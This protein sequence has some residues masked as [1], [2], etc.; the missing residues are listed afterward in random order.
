MKNE[1]R[2]MLGVCALVVGVYVY[3]VH[4]GVLVSGSL[5]AADNYYNLLVQGF[6]VGQLSLKKE[7]PLGL[8]QLADPYDPAENG[9]YR[10]APYGMHDMSYFKGKLYLYLG[11]TPALI[12]FWPYVALTGHYLSYGQAGVIFCVMG[13]LASA[14]L[15]FAF[16][17]TCF[18]ETSVWVVAA[19]GLALGLATS[20]PVLLARCDV[21]EVAISC[22]YAL[23][24]LALAAIWRAL[25][26]PE[27][28]K[29]LGWLAAAS[30]TYGLAVGARPSLLF[31][32]IVLLVP[33]ASAW[34]ERQK[35]WIQL[36][37][38]V[39]PIAL[40]G[41]G[42]MLYNDLRFDS[43]F[44]FG[45]RYQLAAV[46]QLTTRFFSPH[47]LWFNF[48]VYFLGPT[49]WTSR[50]PFVHEVPHPPVPLGHMGGGQTFGVL[51]NI[52]LVWLALAAPLGWRGRSAECCPI[53]CRFV[54]VLGILFAINALTLGLFVSVHGRYEVDFLPELLLL[55]VTGVLGMERALASTSE[56]GPVNQFR[57]QRPM[58]WCWS[59]LL[60][61][62]IA[63]N[64]LASVGRCAESD[65][66]LGVALMRLGKVDEA[67]Q[68]F[69]RTLRLNPDFVDARNNLG[70]AFFQKGKFQDAVGQYVEALR[71]NPGYAR[72]HINLGVV[73]GKLGKTEVAIRQYEEALRIDR[74]SSEAH[75]DLGI[76]LLQQN[77][78]QEA[79][80]QFEEALRIDPY[81]VVAHV[82]IANGLLLQGKL[83]DSIRHYETALSIDPK[84]AEVHDNL[85]IALAQ[86]GRVPE[87]IKH[88]GEAL[89]LKPDDAEAHL[90]L[91]L[92]LE[93]LGRTTE[94]IEHY[95]QALKIRPDF[96]PARDALTR[97]GAV[98]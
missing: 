78:L 61:L 64:L 94:A 54:T 66:N 5:S 95:Q 62:S 82:S 67:M 7:V 59:I 18:A 84:N 80:A 36:L 15:L 86:V 72:A 33:V 46:R 30:L 4:S 57:W 29:R 17:R 75:T 81:Y 90:N 96:T 73:M 56:S 14:Y 74:D 49:R 52:P 45:T 58:R 26:E 71:M 65:F 31:G 6:R 85:G 44:E 3:T 70:N 8:T 89:G 40:V 25:R 23:T 47:Y 19:C 39:G 20:V 10:F 38:A 77:R 48:R 28:R 11:V 98:Q 37:A 55:A 68:Q 35:V 83:Q 97:L 12:L 21:W 51:T 88:W 91:A 42:L 16:W 93:K 92:A 34:H 69:E 63:F 50:F 87:A 60:C 27:S 24:M 79:I 22:A 41:L 9:L 76:A 1:R 43:A 2:I 53:L 32:A 13:F